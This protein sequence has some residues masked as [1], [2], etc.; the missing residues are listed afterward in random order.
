MLGDSNMAKT[1]INND[2][3]SK[4]TNNGNTSGNTNNGSQGVQG[5][6][7][8]TQKRIENGSGS[9]SATKTKKPESK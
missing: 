9:S 6:G 8:E 5:V 1:K 3:G 4:S 7:T 2:S